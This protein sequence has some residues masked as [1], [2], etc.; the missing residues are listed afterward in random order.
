MATPRFLH[1]LLYAVILLFL[2]LPDGG[3]SLPARPQRRPSPPPPRNRHTGTAGGR[4]PSPA[5]NAN[6][7]QSPLQPK[8][9]RT[10]ILNPQ[11]NPR[12]SPPVPARDRD[13][14]Q[15][16]GSGYGVPSSSSPSSQAHEPNYGSRKRGGNIGS[17]SKPEPASQ[18]DKTPLLDSDQPDV[19]L[20]RK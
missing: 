8:H 20:N 10:G 5:S 17:K 14:A 16:H 4:S 1:L 11:G 12:A 18:S 9:M 7:G 2:A 3:Y 13:R 15:G 6:R 19:G